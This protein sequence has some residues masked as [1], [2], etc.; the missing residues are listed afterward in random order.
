MEANEILA[1]VGAFEEYMPVVE[2]VVPLIGKAGSELRPL[3][4]QLTDFS[5]DMQLRAI[6]RYENAGMS[7]EQAVLLT[8]NTK[9]A[10]ID[11]LKNNNAKK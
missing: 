1:V 4:E 2:K 5:V 8:I 6:T 7:R 10:V 11:A 3:I 9:A